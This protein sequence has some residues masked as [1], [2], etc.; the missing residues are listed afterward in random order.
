MR[1]PALTYIALV[2]LLFLQA[3]DLHSHFCLD[4]QEPAVSLH[5][6]NLNGHPEHEQDEYT[7]DDIENEVNTVMMLVKAKFSSIDMAV[8]FQA[9]ISFSLANPAP[10]LAVSPDSHQTADPSVTLPP[11]RAPPANA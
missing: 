6:E 7:H 9:G 1:H 11:L 10:R 3:G 5:Y 8:N 4:G 2:F